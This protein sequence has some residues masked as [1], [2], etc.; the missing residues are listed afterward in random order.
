MGTWKF[1]SGLL[2]NRFKN[3][4]ITLGLSLAEKGKI[5]SG[6]SIGYKAGPL[7]INYGFNFRDAIFLQ[8]I[9]GIDIAFSLIFKMNRN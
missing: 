2:F 1:S 3:T 7:L 9:K 8:S 5:N 6:F 4:P